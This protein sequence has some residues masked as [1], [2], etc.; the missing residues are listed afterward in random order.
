LLTGLPQN[1]MRYAPLARAQYLESA[2]FLSQYL[3]SSQGDRMGMAHS[4]EGRFPFL[5]YRLVE[6]CN[7]LPARLK[8]RCLNEKYL[9]KQV[10]Q[11]LVPEPIRRRPKRPYR[12]PIHRSLL[13][14]STTAYVGEIL[15]EASLKACGLFRPLA[16]EQMLKKVKTG[17]DLGE[18]DEMALAGVISTQL[19]HHQFVKQFSRPPPL[20]ER[21]RVKVCR[22]GH[23]GE[24]DGVEGRPLR[25]GST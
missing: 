23:S 7:R 17:A 10:A 11:P 21:D 18:T 5:D 25:A 9:L 15:S 20:S 14:A 19:L 16:V 3:L 22:V 2:L 6:F 12:A 8:L 1:F 13:N 4:I 24:A